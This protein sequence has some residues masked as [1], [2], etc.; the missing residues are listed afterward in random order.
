MA[1]LSGVLS[2]PD[3]DTDNFSAEPAAGNFPVD[4]GNETKRD[5]F[6]KI[7][8]CQPIEPFSPP[9]WPA[10]AKQQRAEVGQ[11]QNYSGPGG[12]CFDH[13]VELASVALFWLNQ[14]TPANADGGFLALPEFFR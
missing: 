1:I 10:A 12:D 3:S 13:E 7:G 5:D 6:M 11:F 2:L 9:G 4:P 14:D 8:L